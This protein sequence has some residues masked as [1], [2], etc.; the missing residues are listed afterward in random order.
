MIG[1]FPLGGVA[2]DYCQYA[3]GFEQLGFEARA[4]GKERLAWWG[5]NAPYH[6]YEIPFFNSLFPSS[7]LILMVRD[8]RDVFASTKA[9]LGYDLDTA[10]GAWESALLNGVLAASYLG[11]ERVRQ[12]KYED[13]VMAPR[14]RPPRALCFSGRRVRRSHV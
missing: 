8:P 9:T 2:W 10:V 12:L 7:K 5:D 13:L 3:V 6:V 4:A 1:T 14:A 11:P